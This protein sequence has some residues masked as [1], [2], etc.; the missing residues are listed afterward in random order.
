M[1]ISS[2]LYVNILSSTVGK[3]HECMCLPAS[4]CVYNISVHISYSAG[5]DWYQVEYFSYDMMN[6]IVNDLF[7]TLITGGWAVYRD[8][9]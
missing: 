8:S 1:S 6:R 9:I 5:F 3:H 7:M 2:H 4:L